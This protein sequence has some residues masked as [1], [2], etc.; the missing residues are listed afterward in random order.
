MNRKD[1]FSTA[2]KLLVSKGAG[3]IGNNPIVR[4]LE[5]IAAEQPKP[6]PKRKHRPPGANHDDKLFRKLCTGCDACMIA[7]PVNVIMI[8]NFE[9]RYPV[10]YPDTDPCVHCEGYPCIQ[11]CPTGALKLD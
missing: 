2:W 8:E 11:A 5:K 7:C 10:I 3:L 1:F 6:S 9:L 4:G